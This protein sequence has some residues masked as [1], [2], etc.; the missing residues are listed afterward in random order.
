[1]NRDSWTQESGSPGPHA[2]LPPRKLRRHSLLRCSATAFL[3]MHRSAQGLAQ[4]P[5]TGWVVSRPEACFLVVLGAGKLRWRC[6][7]LWLVMRGPFLACR[8]VA[9]CLLL[10]RPFPSA[11]ERREGCLSSASYRLRAPPLRVPLIIITSY[12]PCL[13]TLLPWVLGLQ[14]KSFRG[15]QFRPGHISKHKNK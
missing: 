8:W 5:Q 10:T 15:T 11:E 4:K 6:W 7:L 2:I 3:L 9:A 1:M 13:Q 14:H 12:E